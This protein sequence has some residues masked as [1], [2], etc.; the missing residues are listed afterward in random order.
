M[1]NNQHTKEHS[2][3]INEHFELT[4]C[5]IKHATNPTINCTYPCTLNTV[6]YTTQSAC[7]QDYQQYP[8]S[9][10]VKAPSSSITFL[11]GNRWCR[12]VKW[13]RDEHEKWGV[14]TSQQMLALQVCVCV[15]V[16]VC[17]DA[18]VMLKDTFMC[19]DLLWWSQ[20]SFSIY[21]PCGLQ[22]CRRWHNIQH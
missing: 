18:H 11:I 12:S 7:A 9:F 4:F 17:I 1:S 15:R 22:T 10:Q 19:T 21:D 3:C 6:L 2:C 14:E 8:S 5:S 20:A 13:S 16:C